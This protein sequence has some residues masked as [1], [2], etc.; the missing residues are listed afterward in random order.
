MKVKSKLGEEA[1]S[2]I[3]SL[4]N[5]VTE[6][7]ENQIP[8]T[9]TI[10]AFTINSSWECDGNFY[11]WRDDEFMGEVEGVDNMKAWMDII[12]K[13]TVGKSSGEG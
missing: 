1:Y 7:L 13:A 5:R 11:V 3:H 10:G 4:V 6:L 2:N 9:I 12:A 8:H